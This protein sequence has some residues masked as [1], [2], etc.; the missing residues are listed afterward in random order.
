MTGGCKQCHKAHTPKLV[1][2]AADVPSQNCAACHAKAFDLLSATTTK[3]K[4]LKCAFCHK[5][6]HRTIPACQDCHGSRHPAGFRV[7]FPQCGRCHKIAHDLN[8]WGVAV[9][10]ET[11]TVA[12][13]QQ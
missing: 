8:N 11:P 10:T 5:D 12:P 13:K 2:Y 6:K 1:S 3:H 7:K 4:T 9:S